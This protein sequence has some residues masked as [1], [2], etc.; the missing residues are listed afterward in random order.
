M[1]VS[2]ILLIL[3]ALFVLSWAVGAYRRLKRQRRHCRDTAAPIPALLAQ[4]HALV[5][6]LVELARTRLE[7][8]RQLL[9][10]SVA[11]GNAATAAV[12]RWKRPPPEADVAVQV[13]DA[14]SALD[15]QF[16]A[17]ELAM[18]QAG[19]PDTDPEARRLLDALDTAEQ[20]IDIACTVYNH[21][22][23]QYNASRSQ[24]PSII[25]AIVFAFRPVGLVQGQA[26]KLAPD[27][28]V[29]TP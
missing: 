28:T 21:A 2:T 1:T 5:V 17:L 11:A 16:T 14:E 9:E 4:R 6:P 3:L 8:D 23:A 10:E 24:F 7:I 27:T 20:D 15:V 12:R 26:A 25:V 18:R 13:G 19:L 29:S 22:A